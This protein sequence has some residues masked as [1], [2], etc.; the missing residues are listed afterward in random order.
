MKKISLLLSGIAFIGTLTV[1]M[2]HF[3][4]TD[5]LATHG[6]FPAPTYSVDSDLQL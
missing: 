4:Q 1:G 5:Q 2:M 3:S 6:H